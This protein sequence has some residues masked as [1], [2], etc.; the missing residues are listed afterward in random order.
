LISMK[1]DSNSISDFMASTSSV[2]WESVV[3]K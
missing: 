3:E 1:S 2:F